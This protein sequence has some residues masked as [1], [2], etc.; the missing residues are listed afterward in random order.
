MNQNE[1]HLSYQN[2]I[3]RKIEGNSTMRF[4]FFNLAFEIDSASHFLSSTL[5]ALPLIVQHDDYF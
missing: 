3:F 5:Y 1:P 2:I 4:A